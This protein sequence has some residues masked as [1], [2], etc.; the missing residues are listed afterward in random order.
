VSFDDESKRLS[1]I[2]PNLERRAVITNLVRSFFL[3]QGFLE[4][5]TPVR[6]RSVA[7]E[8]FIVPL[9][10]EDWFLSTSPE[11]YMKRLLACGYD[12]LFQMAHCFRRGEI[13]RLH[14][15]EFTLLEWYRRNAGYEET[16][17]DTER[18]I[19]SVARSLGQGT[20]VS[21]LGRDIDL[22]LP[23]PRV[24][25]SDAFKRAAGWDPVTEPDGEKF[26][27]DLVSKVIPSF[28]ASRPLV[29]TG[30]PA[31]MASL[32]RLNADDPRIAERAEV[33]IAGLELANAYSE[34]NDPEEQ[35]RRFEA[36]AS[37]I[38]QAGG[39]ATLSEKFLEAVAHMP[40]CGGIALGVDRLVMLFCNAASIRDV[41]AFPHEWA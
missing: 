5:E 37:L 17:S 24:T 7:P 22:R 29:L 19:T 12:K 1:R 6:V 25:V 35:R 16:I 20:S 8:Q 27:L 3:D 11:L 40:P 14:N 23:W 26:D 10:S 39:R 34:L 2:K 4:V 15:P 38:R 36:E 33:F 31:P 28:D 41:L 9:A 21:Y 32:A 13:G 18:L 30:Y